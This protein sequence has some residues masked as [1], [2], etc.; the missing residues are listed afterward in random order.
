MMTIQLKMMCFAYIDE[1]WGPYT[2]D[3]FI[4]IGTL[5]Q[6]IFQPAT[7]ALMLSRKIG[8]RRQIGYVP[9]RN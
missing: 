4:I 7:M 1:P 5:I 8:L 3:R 2:I 9:L 6:N